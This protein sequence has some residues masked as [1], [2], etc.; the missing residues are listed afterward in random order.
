MYAS[1]LDA[2]AAIRTRLREPL[3]VFWP[4]VGRFY[5]GDLLVVGRAVNGW[6]DL[7][8]TN[9]GR[10][11]PQVAALA[12]HT[13][14]GTVNGCPMGW[15]MDR[16]KSRTAGYNAGSSQFWQV[17]RAVALEGRPNW[18][19]D[20]PSHLAWTNLAKVAPLEGG[21]PGGRLLATQ[22]D[23]G[24]QLLA[25]EVA[26]LSPRRVVALTGRWWFEPFAQHLGLDVRWRDGLVQGVADRGGC[27]WVV[28]VH[29]MTRRPSMVASQ[30]R[31]A[32]EL[33]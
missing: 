12:R 3:V 19:S 16:W 15:V 5:D 24:P 30:I 14:E 4:R 21:N 26:E 25:Q 18:V 2:V 13:A 7:W 6:I 22:R 29:P 10:S 20:W 33:A 17:V 23:M 1:Q 8:R 27:R 28:A 31:E 11:A 32:L 9:D